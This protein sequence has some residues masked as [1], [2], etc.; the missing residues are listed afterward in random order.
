MLSPWAKKHGHA[1]H[2]DFRRLCADPAIAKMIHESMVAVGKEA[3]LKGF[4]QVKAVHLH[5]E[6][7]S[8]E[9]GL[10]TPT[11]KLKRPQARQAFQQEIDRMYAGLK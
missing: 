3:G 11:F 5:P 8:V 6:L 2:S 7:F 4:E 9:N 10:F 1:G